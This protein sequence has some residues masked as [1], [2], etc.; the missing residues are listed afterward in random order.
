LSVFKL[1]RIVV[2]LSI[3]FVIVVGS[4]MTE[5]RMASWERPILVTVYPIIADN[6][7]ATERFVRN[8]DRDSFEAINRFLER[9]ARPYGF[10][11][12]PPLRFQWAAPSRESPPAVPGQ[13]DRL[14]IALWS[15]KMR[16]WSW[17][18]TLGDDLVSPDIQM[19]VLYHSLSGNNELGISVGMRKGRYGIVKAYAQS[20]LQASNHVVFTH[21]LLHVLGA[22]D[23]YVLSSGEPIHPDGF[24]D[25]DRSPLFPQEYAEIMGGRIPLGPNSSAM[26]ESL[27]QCR[28][29]RLTAFEIGFYQQL[30]PGR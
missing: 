5:K 7:P 13:R 16:W 25:P 20:R 29:G 12:T 3:L 30:L 15:L 26:P 4:W 18:Q 27:N 28:I 17:R 9:E 21:E 23:K 8:F 11:V 19:F 10:T 22:T 1:L 2:L 24:A 6:D 14:G